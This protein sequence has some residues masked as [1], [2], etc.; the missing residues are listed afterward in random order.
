MAPYKLLLRLVRHGISTH[1]ADSNFLDA[2]EWRYFNEIM[3]IC[4]FDVQLTFCIRILFLSILLRDVPDK[5]TFIL[6]KA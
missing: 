3:Y 2:S 4:T 6:Y 5:I 1:K